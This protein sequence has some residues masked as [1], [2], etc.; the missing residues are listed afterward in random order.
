METFLRYVAS[1]ASGICSRII[2]S[3]PSL[4]KWAWSLNQHFLKQS[5]VF[6]DD[7][8]VTSLEWGWKVP[9]QGQYKKS[10]TTWLHRLSLKHKTKKLN[11][12]ND[13]VREK[14][15]AE[16]LPYKGNIWEGKVSFNRLQEERAWSQGHN[17]QECVEHFRSPAEWFYTSA[18]HTQIFNLYL[19]EER[20]ACRQE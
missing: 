11:Q 6:T 20:K 17:F 3:L 4:Q 19:Q 7:C 2:W 16:L 14:E 8:P 12:M 9:K 13:R 15:K 10:K 5:F 18:Q 1:T